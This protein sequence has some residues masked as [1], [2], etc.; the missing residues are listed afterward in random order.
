M[1]TRVQESILW[2]Q[3]RN[4]ISADGGLFMKW[5][6]PEPYTFDIFIDEILT[7]S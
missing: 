2:A 3:G 5:G 1:L 6:E 7:D 4:V